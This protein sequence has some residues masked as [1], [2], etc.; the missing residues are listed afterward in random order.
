[1]ITSCLKD[2]FLFKFCQSVGNAAKNFFIS[3]QLRM[4]DF[5]FL[6]YFK[7]L[8]IFYNLIY[9]THKETLLK[10]TTKVRTRWCNFSRID[11]VIT[12][13]EK[14]AAVCS[15]KSTLCD[16][17]LKTKSFRIKL[18]SSSELCNIDLHLKTKSR[19]GE[20]SCASS[21]HTY[22]TTCTLL[23]HVFYSRCLYHT[24]QETGAVS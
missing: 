12:K 22:H 17:I 5:F 7:Q 21:Q 2:L 10:N 16:I 24:V 13:W 20:K 15:S 1:M 9:K 8:Q 19:V 18:M 23:L 4:Q 11:F 14:K 6:T 3:Q